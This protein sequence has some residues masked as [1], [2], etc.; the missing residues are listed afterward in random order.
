MKL[1][2]F[3]GKKPEIAPGAYVHP[4]AILIGGV[5]IADNCYIGP[6][7]V[8]RAD[9]G[10]IVVERDSNIQENCV[11]HAAPDVTA[12]L[13]PASHIG[14]GAIIHGVNLGRHVSIGMGAIIDEETEIGDECI[15]GASC[16]IPRGTKI[17][18]LK[19]VIGI[20]ARIVGD[21]S[22]EQR[23]YTKWATDVYKKL[24]ARCH[25]GLHKI[26]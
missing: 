10:F 14:H 8:L 23:E 7:A 21:V 19:V 5:S 4:E 18:A 26:E 1:Y 13:G 12:L 25:K 16:F 3:E 11:I 20:P 24:P 15:I 22:D 6:G 17:P 2:E 9:W